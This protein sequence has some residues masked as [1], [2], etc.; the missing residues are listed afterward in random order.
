MTSPLVNLNTVPND[1]EKIAFSVTIHEAESRT[2]LCWA[3][4]AF[5]RLGECR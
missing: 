3:N 4:G 2:K 5:I 1:I